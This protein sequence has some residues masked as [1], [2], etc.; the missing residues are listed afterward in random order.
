MSS[1][2]MPAVMAVATTSM[3]LAAPS[4]PT[5]CAPST[6]PLLRSASSLTVIG[7]APGK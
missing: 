7:A 2:V 5:I 6:F 4:L 1:T 3:R